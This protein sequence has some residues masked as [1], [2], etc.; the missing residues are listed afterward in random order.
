MTLQGR[1]RAKGEEEMG[2]IKQERSWEMI[3]GQF[4]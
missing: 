2:M 3:I 1:G 4:E